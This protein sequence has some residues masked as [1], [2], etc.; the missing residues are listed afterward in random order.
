MKD[1]IFEWRTELIFIFFYNRAIPRLPLALW[2]LVHGSTTYVWLQDQAVLF[3][4]CILKKP[5]ELYTNFSNYI[6]PGTIC[7]GS[8]VQKSVSLVLWRASDWC[9]CV[10]AV[11]YIYWTIE[12]VLQGDKLEALSICMKQSIG[13]VGWCTLAGFVVL[14]V[15]TTSAMLS[16]SVEKQRGTQTPVKPQPFSHWRQYS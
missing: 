4:K 5:I 13:L 16:S 3:S 6:I 7:F 10:P 2:F 11:S 8:V 9:K 1:Q 15:E 12:I 14:W